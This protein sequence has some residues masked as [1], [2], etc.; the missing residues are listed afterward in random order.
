MSPATATALKA[1]RLLSRAELPGEILDVLREVESVKVDQLLR[2]IEE[3]S[4]RFDDIEAREVLWEL[5][6]RKKVRLNRDLSL[7][8]VVR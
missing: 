6:D 3:R 1:Q 2:T 8:L 4:G 5:I 7:A